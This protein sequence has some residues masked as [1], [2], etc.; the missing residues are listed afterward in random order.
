M[1]R[2]TKV[3]VFVRKGVSSSLLVIPLQ[4]T[5]CRHYS[6]NPVI[7]VDSWVV[8]HF[9]LFFVVFFQVLFSYQ[10]SHIAIIIVFF[11]SVLS[12]TGNA[13]PF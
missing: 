1:Q 3:V 4:M 13:G 12:L 2:I 11:I 10:F 7:E 9:S 8:L 5:A 6:G